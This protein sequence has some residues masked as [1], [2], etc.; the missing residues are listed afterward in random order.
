MKARG[1]SFNLCLPFWRMVRPLRRH[2]YR[3][4]IWVCHLHSGHLV[5]EFPCVFLTRLVCLMSLFCS[6]SLSASCLPLF[7]ALLS[8]QDV[9]G[10]GGGQTDTRRARPA[11]QIQLPYTITCNLIGLWPELQKGHLESN[12]PLSLYLFVFILNQTAP[13]PDNSCRSCVCL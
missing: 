5:L 13:N 9:Y 11:L 3:H 10:S 4:V 1:S 8:L 12:T 6:F 7:S 2:L